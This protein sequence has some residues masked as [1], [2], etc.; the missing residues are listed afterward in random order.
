[1]REYTVRYGI[2][3]KVRA[4]SRDEA[5]RKAAEGISEVRQWSPYRISTAAVIQR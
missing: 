3:V 5:L 2:Y 4:S 1:M